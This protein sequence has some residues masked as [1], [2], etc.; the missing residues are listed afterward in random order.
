MSESRNEAIEIIGKLVLVSV[1]AAF[2][3]GMTYVPTNDQLKI[4]Y[5][6]SRKITLNE[7]MPQADS[8]E[9]VY[10]DTVINEEGDREILYYCA[11]DTS[12]NLIGYAFFREY[13]GSQGMIEVAGGVDSSFRTITGIDIMRHSET[14]GLGAKITEPK[15]KDQFIN[16]ELEKLSL[17]GDGGAI[18]SI[19]GATISSQAVVDALNAQVSV[20]KKAEA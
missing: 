19:T 18:D 3:L 14:P 9:A 16:V 7:I 5:E 11:K 12:G 10:G 15:F 13:T 8:F 6:E 1:V 17:S 4:N 20:V 2:L